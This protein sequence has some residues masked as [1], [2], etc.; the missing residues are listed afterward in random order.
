MFGGFGQEHVLNHHKTLR[1]HKR[2]NAQAADG[3]GA[4]D[5][6]RFQF[7]GLRRFHHLRQAQAFFGRQLAPFLLE[8]GGA[9]DGLVSRQKIG[10]KP[11]FAGSARI[12]VIAQT[13]QLAPVK[14]EAK[15]TN[16]SMSGR[17]VRN[18]RR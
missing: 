17:A 7:A 15:L 6:K 9:G 14:V 10:I 16:F 2:I 18:R 4:H 12:R 3:I 5:V 1:K 13:D 8:F 11:H